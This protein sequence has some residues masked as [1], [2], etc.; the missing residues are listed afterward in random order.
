MATSPSTSTTSTTP[1]PNVFF[2]S[3]VFIG[4]NVFVNTFPVSSNK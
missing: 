3:N 4:Q 1:I 2:G